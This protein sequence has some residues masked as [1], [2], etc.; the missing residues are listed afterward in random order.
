RPGGIAI[1]GEGVDEVRGSVFEHG[2][3]RYCY[4]NVRVVV[5]D[6]TGYRAWSTNV[7]ARAGSQRQ[8]HRLIRFHRH[9]SRRVDGYSRRRVPRR[10]G[11]AAVG[12]GKRR[13][14][15]L[16]VVSAKRSAAG[17]REVNGQRTRGIAITCEGVD[18]IW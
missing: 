1:T 3:R 9:V 12:G 14:T 2:R 8:H 17:H 6:R 16:R 5:G 7:V 15:R 13:R 18:E 10:E 4:R 11:H